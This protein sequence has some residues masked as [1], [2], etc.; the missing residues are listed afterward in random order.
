MN[1]KKFIVFSIS[2]LAVLFGNIIY[3]LSCGPEPDPYDY[4][5]S[6]YNPYLKGQGYEP[7]Y[8]TSLANFYDDATPQE[9][10]TNTAEWLKYAND[11]S[12]TEKD[13]YRYIYNFSADQ[14]AQIADCSEKG[15]NCTLADSARSN[16]FAMYLTKNKEA[17]RYLDFAKNCEPFVFNSDPWADPVDN[18]KPMSELYSK[19]TK[20]IAGV[21]DKS[22]R[23]RYQFQLLR[24]THYR[25]M[26]HETIEGFD[27]NFAKNDDGSLIYN[28]SLALKAGAL[29]RLKDTTTSAYL[30]SKVFDH[31]PGLR[32]MC[33][34][35]IMWTN[36]GAKD[37]YPLCKDDHEKANVAAIFGMSDPFSDISGLRTV[38]KLD[39]ASPSMNILLSREINKLEASYM[40]PRI[41]KEVDSVGIAM[42]WGGFGG[43]WW[44]SDVNDKFNY[45]R[46]IGTLQR[47]ADSVAA[48]GKVKDPDLWRVSAAYVAYMQRDFNGARARLD[49][50]KI[51]DAAIKDQWELVNLLV[52]ISQQQRIDPVYEAKLLGSFKW[53]DAK[54]KNQKDYGFGYTAKDA[55]YA[56]AYRNLLASVVAPMYHKQGELMKEALIRGRCDSLH[57][58]NTPYDAS[59]MIG[60]HM[61]AAQLI[62]LNDFLKQPA[63]TDYD[64]Y[65][66]GFFPD[67]LNMD[68]L[69]GTAYMRVHNFTDALPWLK[70]VPAKKQPVSYQ[71]FYAQL[72][73]FGE[74]TAVAGRKT[75]ITISQFCE[76]VVKL[77]G[78][79]K[80]QPVDAK[81]YY[82]LGNAMFS[83]SYYGQTWY[84]MK[85]FRPSTEW[86]SAACEKDPFDR[87]YFGCYDAEIF[88]AKAAQ[89]AT[90]KEFRAKCLYLAA[91]SSQKHIAPMTDSKLF[92]AALIR[93]RY[94]QPLAANYKETR[95]YQDVYNECSYL[96]DYVRSTKK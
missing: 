69:I 74:D 70:K 26:Y 20:L 84:F 76:R 1:Y 44:F 49:K 8:F 33:Y 14:I 66:A 42:G 27:K 9:D 48:E 23:E 53:L 96:K 89:A 7:F 45:N 21:K 41:N 3:T 85:D 68:L 25:K 80:T 50:Y 88:Y 62:Q 64:K 60:N 2:F 22:I 13:V 58:G 86:Y 95:F 65:L 51:K 93:N 15:G 11:K 87:Q 39:P 77:L 82:E 32:Q 73:D 5:L 55:F 6:Y 75:P 71:V 38:Y 24:L 43:D 72:Q 17:A 28:K 59:E 36:T 47:F 30:F 92:Y 79:T 81:V 56:R 18:S 35:N 12:V 37:V 34:T 31:A 83:T 16:T 54:L 10:V 40:T 52:N 67:N 29:L 94:F 4:Y 91:R 19:G 46:Y 63:K 78:Q 61:N 90:D 57:S